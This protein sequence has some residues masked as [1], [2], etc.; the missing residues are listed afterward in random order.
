MSVSRPASARPRS[1]V[2]TEHAAVLPPSAEELVA[3]E[4]D[5]IGWAALL[6]ARVEEA[7]EL[8]GL[9]VTHPAPT[10]TLNYLARVRWSAADFERNL[11]RVVAEMSDRGVWPSLVVCDGLS[12]PVDIAD[13]LR[14]AG[15]ISVFSDRM[16]YTRHP[17]VVPHLDPT[18]R[19]EAVTPASALEAI[20]LETQVFGLMPQETGEQAELLAN[21]VAEGTSRGFLLRLGPDVVATARLVPGS[22]VAGL[23]AIGVDARQRRRGYGRMLTAI[24]TRAGLATGHK[25][26]WLSVLEENAAAV[27]MYRSLGFEFSFRWSRWVAPA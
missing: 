12:D 26:V 14:A 20:R 4:A 7:P 22:L 21:S 3:M 10:S 25:L 11:E 27:E 16:M 24:A 18:L 6:G 17:A 15:W 23:H 19:V 1:D 2:S 5:R 8:G 9:L 13:R